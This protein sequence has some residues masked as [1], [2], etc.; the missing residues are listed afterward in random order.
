MWS[1]SCPDMGLSYL[2][3]VFL[4]PSGHE[5]KLNVVITFNGSQSDTGSP[6]ARP[7]HWRP[8][9]VAFDFISRTRFFVR[10]TRQNIS[11]SRTVSQN[12]AN[13]TVNARQPTNVAPKS[14]ASFRTPDPESATFVLQQL[15]ARLEIFCK[16]ME[17]NFEVGPSL[18]S[19]LLR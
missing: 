13:T 18:C 15:L 1:V 7:H 9:A 19:C 14:S 6:S 2:E 17:Q 10:M 8:V 4:E 16:V 11:R 12:T 3:H 5:I